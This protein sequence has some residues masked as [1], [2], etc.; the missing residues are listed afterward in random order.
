M[1]GEKTDFIFIASAFSLFAVLFFGYFFLYAYGKYFGKEVNAVIIATPGSAGRKNN[2]AVVA[3][4]SEAYDYCLSRGEYNSG[5]FQVGTT[6]K[7]RVVP[8]IG[9]IVTNTD[10]PELPVAIIYWC[11]VLALGKHFLKSSNEA[12]KGYSLITHTKLL[13]IFL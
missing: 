5:K 1:F 7:V 3:V 10:Y 12:I 8:I 6:I 9:T 2:K 11:L 4:D 13:R